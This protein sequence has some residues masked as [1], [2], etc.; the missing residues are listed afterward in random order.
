MDTA[1]LPTRTGF[2]EGSKSP[3]S[4]LRHKRPLSCILH[5]VGPS[6]SRTS[7]T[8]AQQR[9]QDV[10]GE[11]T[12]AMSLHLSAATNPAAT[13]AEAPAAAAA[14]TNSSS[15]F[16]AP[17]DLSLSEGLDFCRDGDALLRQ[18]H[19]RIDEMGQQLAAAASLAAS[20][21]SSEGTEDSARIAHSTSGEKGEEKLM[22]HQ[23]LLKDEIDDCLHQIHAAVW[24]TH[25]GEI[26]P[27]LKHLQNS[28]KELQQQEEETAERTKE[29]KERIKLK[30]AEK[31]SVKFCLEKTKDEFRQARLDLT[32][33]ELEKIPAKERM[34]LLE[35][36]RE[37]LDRELR[38]LAAFSPLFIVERAA[39]YITLQYRPEGSSIDYEISIEGLDL[40]FAEGRSRLSRFFSV[41]VQPPNDRV[42]RL[43][44]SGIGEL[45]QK[46]STKQTA[47][48]QAREQARGRQAGEPSVEAAGDKV[49]E[50]IAAILIKTLSSSFTTPSTPPRYLPLI[51]GRPS[52][53]AIQTN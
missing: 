43:L 5:S 46:L 30:M 41:H 17:W 21:A 39:K 34:Q 23:Q 32:R 3:L 15:S 9:T 33:E 36:K 42:R 19:Q 52:A 20:G 50:Y 51:S 11:K 35:T 10:T 13:A 47:A 44:E 12:N 28:L 37:T 1:G 2:D 8:A 4:R 6:S 18:L 48:H 14:G 29:V 7:P 25:G 38:S 49:V 26:L 24:L 22:E 40:S 53:G 31:E 27:Y 45:L 16:S